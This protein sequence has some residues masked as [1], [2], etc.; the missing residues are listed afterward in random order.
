MVKEIIEKL[1]EEFNRYY[2]QNPI[3][4]ILLFGSHTKGESFEN[5]DI[6]ICIVDEKDQ[7]R[8]DILRKAWQIVGDN[9]DLW[10]FSE[11]ADY[12]KFE[13]LNN[14]Q[15]ILCDDEPALYEFFYPFL[16]LKQDYEY[17][18]KSSE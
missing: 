7:D 10:L 14:H 15:I 17:R 4:A 8:V 9:Y 1:K 18:I 11:L 5:S 16:K 12:M 6:D 13:I 2:R 3:K